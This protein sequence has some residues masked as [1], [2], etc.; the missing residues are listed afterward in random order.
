MQYASATYPGKKC[1][2]YQNT[3]L[4]ANPIEASKYKRKAKVMKISMANRYL[5]LGFSINQQAI[6]TGLAQ[7]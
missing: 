1:F 2:Y 4:L 3:S 6:K 5:V 7:G